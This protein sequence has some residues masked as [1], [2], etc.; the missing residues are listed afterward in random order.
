MGLGKTLEAL[1]ASVGTDSRTFLVFTKKVSIGVWKQEIGKWLGDPVFTYTGQPWQRRKA[2]QEWSSTTARRKW[3]I[4]NYAH[5]DSIAQLQPNWDHLIY[6]ESHLLRNRKSRTL[7]QRA[8]SF[9]SRYLYLL[10]G[11]P[12]M[13]QLDDLWTSLHL[14]D[15]KRFSSYWRF[16]NQWFLTSK[17]VFGGYTIDGPKNAKALR[18]F[19]A[20]Y[21]LRRTKA[22]VLLDLPPKVRQVIPL[23]LGEEQR[24]LYGQMA[25]AM[26]ATWPTS[27]D[28]THPGGI[29]LAPSQMAK[30]TRLRQIL[31][32]PTLIGAPYASSALDGVREQVESEWE[33]GNPVA[34]FTPFAKAIPL[35]MDSLPKG[36]I[37]FLRG[38]T[39][40]RVLDETIQ[41][42]QES[43]NPRRAIVCSIGMSTGFTL[44]AAKVAIF[45]GYDWVPDN[46]IQA[47]DRLHRFGQRDSVRVLYFV[48]TGTIDDHIMD[49]LDRKT[50]WRKLLDDPKTLLKGKEHA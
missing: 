48:H 37:T 17:G 20:P 35:I 47:E 44:T 14:I 39:H 5:M 19:L 12:I 29:L 4:S 3:L 41:H 49:V 31:V 9:R 30:I 10:T 27:E 16:V 21:V 23:T 42:F 24:E 34:I 32:S 15:P 43:Q 11:S 40:E 8:T 50:T 6:D 22:S 38:G 7:F 25:D 45:I 13:N 33:A 1:A 36:E 26:L 18:E 2:W 46:N 28:G